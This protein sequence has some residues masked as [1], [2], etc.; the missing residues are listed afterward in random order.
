MPN[1]PLPLLQQFFYEVAQG[2]TPGQLAALMKMASA[3][4]VLFGSDF[5]FRQAVQTVA[6]LDD[7]GFP[8]AQRHAIDRD[9][10]IRILPGLRP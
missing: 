8:Q 10:A 9:N 4:Q 1:G 6:G 3:S 5:P 7:F 2:T